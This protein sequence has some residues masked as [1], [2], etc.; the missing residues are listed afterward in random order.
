M[1]KKIEL[2]KEA[3]VIDL[4]KAVSVADRVSLEDVRLIHSR[5][6]LKPSGIKG[7]YGINIEC[8]VDIQINKEKQIIIVLPCFELI[9]YV[10]DSKKNEPDFAI[11]ASFAL[12]YSI[13]KF[14][15]LDEDNYHSFGEAN[16]V[17]NAWP[18]WRE[19]VQNTT[20]RMGLSSIN[21]PVFRIIPSK[22]EEA[23]TASKK[24][25]KKKKSVKKKTS[26]Q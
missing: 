24:A 26:S 10:V 12:T 9:A 4:R 25:V 22:K 11:S 21:V 23:K 14:E 5:C 17:Y 18:Y 2:H 3:K 20:S 8:N 1:S 16:G 13:N 6:Y 15:G 19:F 7:P